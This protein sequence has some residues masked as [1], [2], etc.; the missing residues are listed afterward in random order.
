[1]YKAQKS[2]NI[3]I[4]CIRRQKMKHRYRFYTDKA[5]I[6]WLTLCLCVSQCYSWQTI[7]CI[8]IWRKAWRYQRGNQKP[9]IEEGQTIQWRTG[10]TKWQT[11]IYKTLHRTLK[12]V[13]H[14]LA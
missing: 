4:K 2:N 9:Y 7:V 5:Y 10:G 14:E 8:H 11:T 6:H 3:R 13:Q 1:M 12:I